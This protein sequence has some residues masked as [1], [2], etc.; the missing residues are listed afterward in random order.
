MRAAFSILFWALVA[1]TSVVHF[2]VALTLFVV[3]WPF[4]R[5][6]RV[7]HLYSCVWAQ[8]FFL[9]N[10]LWRL[11]IEHRERLPWRGAAVL[12]ANH[13]SLGDVLVLFGLYRPFKWVAKESAFSLPFIGWNMRL[14]GY[15]PIRRGSRESVIEMMARCDAWLERGVPVLLFPEG[16]RSFD[17]EIRAF[18]DGAFQLAVRHGCPVIPIVLTG[19]S[20]LLPKHG[21]VLD[22]RADCVVDVLEPVLPANF[23]NQVDLLRDHVRDMMVAHKAS[24]LARSA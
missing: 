3:T 11:R 18:K 22:T 23:D 20:P 6:R 14:N 5:N 17:G 10:P 2:L 21:I 4:D 7:L 16:T 15:V 8:T 19:T 13:E 9:F 12:V 24:M 1:V